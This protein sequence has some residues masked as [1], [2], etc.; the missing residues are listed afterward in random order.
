MN[1]SVNANSG[2]LPTST[3][4]ALEEGPYEKGRQ[5]YT[6]ATSRRTGFDLSADTILRCWRAFL[7]TAS[8]FALWSLCQYPGPKRLYASEC[9]GTGTRNPAFLIEAKHGAVAA[10]NER[11]STIGVEVLKEGGNAVDAAISSALCVGVVNMFS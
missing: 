8:A 7:V 11:C 1:W 6:F 5:T 10:E 9:P 4:K 3:P 2:L